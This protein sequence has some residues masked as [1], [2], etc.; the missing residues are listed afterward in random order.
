[1]IAWKKANE[2][3]TLYATIRETKIIPWSYNIVSDEWKN[4]Q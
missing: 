1:M 3:R 4:Q 2:T